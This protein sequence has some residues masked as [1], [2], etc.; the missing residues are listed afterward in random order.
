[1]SAPTVEIVFLKPTFVP[2]AMGSGI[3]VRVKAEEPRVLQLP[4][5]GLVRVNVRS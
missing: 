4:A 5:P 3:G 1:V 2:Q